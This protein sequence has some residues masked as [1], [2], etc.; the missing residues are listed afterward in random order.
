MTNTDT[1]Q[2]RPLVREDASKYKTVTLGK[3]KFSGQKSQIGLD[4]KTYWVAVSRTV[5][6]TSTSTLFLASV[7][8]KLVPTTVTKETSLS[9]FS[10]GSWWSHSNIAPRADSTTVLSYSCYVTLRYMFPSST[11]VHMCVDW[12]HAHSFGLHILQNTSE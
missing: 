6:S 8:P 2:T 11:C 3:K 4:T 7:P 12:V 1:W 9:L 10:Y 5:T